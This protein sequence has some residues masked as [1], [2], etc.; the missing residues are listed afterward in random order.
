MPSRRCISP[1]QQLASTARC[2]PRA[3]PS[4]QR[5]AATSRRC[6]V[7]PRRHHNSS[8]PQLVPRRTVI[9]ATLRRRISLR[10]PVAAAFATARC[11]TLSPHCAPRRPQLHFPVSRTRRFAAETHGFGHCNIP[12]PALRVWNTRFWDLQHPQTGDSR[13]KCTVL[14][15]LETETVP[16][17]FISA[18]NCPRTLANAHKT[19]HFGRKLGRDPPHA[20]RRRIPSQATSRREHGQGR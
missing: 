7:S 8:S 1:P 10:H 2:A 16:K 9:A 3:A 6:S 17:P 12:E 11:A 18:R 13:P 20:R 4:L 19:V 14:G 5:F 15:R